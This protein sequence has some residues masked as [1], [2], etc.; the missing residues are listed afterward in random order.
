M[1]AWG[2]DPVYIRTADAVEVKEIRETSTRLVDTFGA[3]IQTNVS[4]RIACH[5]QRYL[6]H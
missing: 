3:G 5:V 4:V 6:C 1:A 2:M